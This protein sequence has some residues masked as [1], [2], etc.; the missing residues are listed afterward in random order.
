MQTVQKY[1]RSKQL[2]PL[3]AKIT[4]YRRNNTSLHSVYSLI[5]QFI[6][7]DLRGSKYGFFTFLSNQR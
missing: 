1:A 6:L 3:K 2:N 4:T 5:A 7:N